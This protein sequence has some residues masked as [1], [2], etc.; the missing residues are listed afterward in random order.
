M[1]T[2]TRRIPPALMVVPFALLL[3]QGSFFALYLIHAAAA[4]QH[5]E[6]PRKGHLGVRLAPLPDEARARQQLER[7]S[8][9]LI[10][11]V[12]PGTTA[13]VDGIKQGDV[14]LAVNGKTVSGVSD[15]MTLIAAMTVGQTFEVSVVRDGQRIV[16]PMTLKERPRDRGDNFDV[17]YHHVVSRGARI[18]TIV[19]RPHATGR[20]PVLFLIK[21]AGPGTIDEPLSGPEPYSRILDEFA[22]SGYV[23]VRVDKPGI[24]DSEG[25]PFADL[26]FETELDAYRQAMIEVLTYTFVDVG[27][28]F[29]FGHSMGG[30]FAP[31]LASEIPITGIAVYGTVAKTWTEYFL[32][33]W[34][35]QAVLA[36]DDPARIDS[37]LRD[38]AAAL[39]YLLI[40]QKSL[41][42]IRRVRPDLRSALAKLAPNGRINGRSVPF[43]SQLATKNLPAYWGKGDAYVMAIWGRSD[44]IASEA[45]HPFIAETV[46]RAR[47]GKGTYVALDDSDHGFRKTTSIEDSFK[48]WNTPGGEFNPRII[49][50]LMDWMEK[51]RRQA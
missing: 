2:T 5:E 36:G 49:T 47:P 1:T 7:R 10:E 20:H 21:G 31:I 13:A 18:R 32:E 25:G 33:N 4:A 39:H 50:T 40:E 41:D 35:R 30:V 37:V 28:V 44:F 24:G 8:G 46:N 17:L 34:R 26:D 38:L 19:T 43:W 42:E 15:V 6:L 45:D 27:K 11:G 51:V 48:R 22:E 9:V 3:V 29:M 23:T 14:L 16:L 12:I